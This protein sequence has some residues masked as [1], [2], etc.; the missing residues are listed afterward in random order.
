[1]NLQPSSIHIIILV[2]LVL[3]MIPISDA[4]PIYYSYGTETEFNIVMTI[5]LVFNSLNLLGTLYIFYRK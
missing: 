5:P 1:M 3:F 2:L 4:S